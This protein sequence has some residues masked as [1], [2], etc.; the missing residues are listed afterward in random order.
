MIQICYGEHCDLADLAGRSIA[1]AREQYKSEFEIPDRAQAILNDKPL[2]KKLEDRIMLEDGDD[3]SFE[4]KE[5][6]K[7]PIFAATLLSALAIT[8]GLFACT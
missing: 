7:K 4:E 5:R 1:E 6:S 2:K 8:G 3:L